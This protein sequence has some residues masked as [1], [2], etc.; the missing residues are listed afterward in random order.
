M[1]QTWETET[2]ASITLNQTA[3]PKLTKTTTI[4]ETVTEP[5]EKQKLFTNPQGQVNRQNTP[6]KKAT[7]EPTQPIDSLPGKKTPERQN[8]VQ[9]R[10][11]QSDSKEIV[12]AAN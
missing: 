8:Q 5:K 11:N 6:Q 10:E 12:Q 3:T 7:L 9:K 4:T 1:A 2:L